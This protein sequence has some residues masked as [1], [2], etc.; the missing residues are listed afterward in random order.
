MKIAA[1]LDDKLAQN[2]VWR[3]LG[4]AYFAAAQLEAAAAALRTFTDRRPYDPE[5]LYWYGAVL[6]QLG[7]LEEARE[8]FNRSIESVN[9]MPS[10]RRAGVRQWGSRARKSR[11]S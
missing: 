8:M 4:A 7:Q 11:N 6:K 9:T 10:H 1:E 5:G 3:E 2:E